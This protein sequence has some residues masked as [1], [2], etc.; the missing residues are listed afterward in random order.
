MTEN[1]NHG[2][3]GAPPEPPKGV[4]ADAALAKDTVAP[5]E[6]KNLLATKPAT[7]LPVDPNYRDPTTLAAFKKMVADIDEAWV[8]DGNTQKARLAQ[9]EVI[10]QLLARV[11]SLEAALMPFANSAVIMSN[12][13]MCLIGAARGD[14]PAGGTWYSNVQGVQLMPNEGLYFNAWDTLGRAFVHN[15]ICETFEKIQKAKGDQREKDAH[16]EEGGK[17]H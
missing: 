15:H 16:V 2:D 6:E 11:Q 17:V 13:R 1:G 9:R 7:Q 14:E 12:A 3:G 5:A 8:Q 10:T 4:L